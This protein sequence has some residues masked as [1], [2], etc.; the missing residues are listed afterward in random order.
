MCCHPGPKTRMN[1]PLCQLKPL[2]LVRPIL[3]VDVQLLQHEF[4]NGHREGNRVIYVS[5]KNDK[6]EHEY[7]IQDT[8]GS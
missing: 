1:V 4:A 6:G 5:I 3:E 7:V 2:A 8:Y